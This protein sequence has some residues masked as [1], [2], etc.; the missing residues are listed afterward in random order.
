MGGKESSWG[1]ASQQIYDVSQE[2]PNLLILHFGINDLGAGVGANSFIDNML[3]I[4]LEL[5]NRCP[6]CEFL[7]LT[8]FGPN[9]MLYD[10]EK[11]DNYIK[12]IKSEITGSIEG[13]AL[14]D[15]FNISKE[16]YKNKKYQDMT[17]NGINH[18]NDYASRI[19]LQAIL[20]TIVK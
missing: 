3:S 13:T 1:A 18:V 14:V 8:P 15:V 11:F 5:K 6:N 7:I 17:A 19:Y 4:V 12:K 2:N 16:L 20:S 9:P 10:Y